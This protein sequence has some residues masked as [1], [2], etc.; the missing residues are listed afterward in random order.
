MNILFRSNL[1]RCQGYINR[2]NESWPNAFGDHVPAV[3]TNI[4]FEFDKWIHEENRSR[5]CSFELGV[6][7]VRYNTTAKYIT[8]KTAGNVI[9]ELH[10]PKGFGY[11][12]HDLGEHVHHNSVAAWE[13]YFKRHVDG[14]A[15]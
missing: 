12:N 3:G 15:Y 10:M 1:D 14:K 7:N 4:E 2:L 9:V 13:V 8:N 6:T 11:V 5:K